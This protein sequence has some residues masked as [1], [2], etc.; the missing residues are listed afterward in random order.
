VGWKET[1]DVQMTVLGSSVTGGAGFS[2]KE[3][4]GEGTKAFIG[5]LSTVIEVEKKKD[6]NISPKEGAKNFTPTRMIE[7]S[8]GKKKGVLK[9]GG[10]VQGESEKIRSL[11]RAGSKRVSLF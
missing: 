7:D 4:E 5:R 10:W 9:K 1:S 8:G 6:P 11:Y 3:G 2:L